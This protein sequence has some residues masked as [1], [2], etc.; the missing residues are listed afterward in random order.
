MLGWKLLQPTMSTTGHRKA[1]ASFGTS[2]P[3]DFVNLSFGGVAV[4][5]LNTQS[6]CKAKHPGDIFYVIFCRVA[7][8]TLSALQR[9]V[10]FWNCLMSIE[11]SSKGILNEIEKANLRIWE[12][13]VWAG[14]VQSF[15]Q[16]ISNMQCFAEVT[17]CG[18]W[19]PRLTWMMVILAWS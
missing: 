12:F 6:I 14:C 3:H 4:Q 15:V 17:L 2:P 13:C 19:M 1:A 5:K 11:R 8:G 9:K 7:L 16:S 10:E 18:H